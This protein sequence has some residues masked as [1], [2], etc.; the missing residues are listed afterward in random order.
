MKSISANNKN[1]SNNDHN[2]AKDEV[3]DLIKRAGIVYDQ[4]LAIV[5]DFIENCN[6]IIQNYVAART[7]LHQ[8]Q[9][10][11]LSN[12]SALKKIV[13]C[14]FGSLSEANKLL[15]SLSSPSSL[16]Y[17]SNSHNKSYE[18]AQAYLEDIMY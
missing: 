12:N 17:N 4:I 14:E 9:I 8:E 16:R 13:A 3:W 7:K 18:K 2:F 1:N 6:R 11:S 15:L 5:T 10:S